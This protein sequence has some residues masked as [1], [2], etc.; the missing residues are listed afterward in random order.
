MTSTPKTSG[1]NKRRTRSPAK[2]FVVRE[3]SE[4]QIPIPEITNSS[5]MPH[6]AAKA[7]A[8]VTRSLVES[9]FTYHAKEVS[10]IRAE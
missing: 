7:S 3:R 8:A 10:K 2:A 1:T 4:Y 5:G 9:F 6:V